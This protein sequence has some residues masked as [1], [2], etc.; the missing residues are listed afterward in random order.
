MHVSAGAS[1]PRII[2]VAKLKSFFIGYNIN[3]Q[4]AKI[5]NKKTLVKKKQFIFAAAFVYLKLKNLQKKHYVAKL[6]KV[7]MP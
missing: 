1:F 5:T 6:V 7:I 4:L 2:I 3:Y